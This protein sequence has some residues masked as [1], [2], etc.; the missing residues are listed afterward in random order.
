M[1]SFPEARHEL[2]A[3]DVSLREVVS[4]TEEAVGH[5]LAEAQQARE[6]APR[7]RRAAMDGYAVRSADTSNASS[8]EPAVLDV[9]G[10]V[11]AGEDP[12]PDGTDS[13]REPG[14]AVR[15]F[16]GAPVP[17]TADAVVMQEQVRRENG[18][19]VVPSQVEQ[20]ANIRDQ[21]E[22]LR[23][24]HTL[25][26]AGTTLTPA[27]VGMLLS[28]GIT[29]VPVYARPEVS[30]LTTGDEL[31]A[32]TETPEPG[33]IR[34]SLQGALRT[35]LY[36]EGR[37]VESRR[38]GDDP[39]RLR[40]VVQHLLPQSDLVL[41]SGGV[42]VGEKDYVRAVLRKCEVQQVFWKVR[43]KPG[44]PAF[45]GRAR[46]AMVLGLP[47]NPVS[48]LV[49]F[50]LYGIPLLRRLAGHSRE[51][52]GLSERRTIL[53]RKITGKPERTEF[54]RAR[55]EW[56]GGRLKSCILEAQGSHMLSGMAHA[57][58]LVGLPEGKEEAQPGTELPVHF[59][60]HSA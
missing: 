16:T 26:Q 17:E 52:C 56:D 22:E 9:E 43:Q 40:D 29:T 2:F 1:R 23:A 19:I 34:D 7:F 24:G 11:P 44:K 33:T 37:H 30:V 25:L 8:R 59:L 45:F 58:S 39:A 47:G 48:A 15:I 12:R 41:V 18:Q 57:N 13:C 55:T 21:G 51:E 3:Q 27:S 36:G 5:V 38:V 60:P 49:C 53:D 35:A 10:E 32:P 28:Q 20:G 46:E 50:Y 4:P 54:F 42:S 6:D 31:V 14:T